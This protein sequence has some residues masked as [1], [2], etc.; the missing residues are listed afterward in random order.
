MPISEH[1]ASARR[2]ADLRNFPA[3]EEA[4]R[5]A[6]AA[7]PDDVAALDLLGFV[8]YFQDRPKEAEV[9]CRRALELR[10]NHA[11]A[12]KGLGLC[13]AKQGAVDEGVGFLDGAIAQDGR[14]FDPHW[15]LV[16]TLVAARRFDDAEAALERARGQLTD[17]A[18]EWDQLARHIEGARGRGAGDGGL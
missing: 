17:R 5:L 7:K 1:L 3:A 14:W 6:L 11:Y 9:A 12:L 15:D 16:V 10:P 18:H 8:L 13:L 4:L 2:L